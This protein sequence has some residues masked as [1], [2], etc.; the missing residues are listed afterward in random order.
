VLQVD[1]SCGYNQCKSAFCDHPNASSCRAKPF[2]STPVA[3]LILRIYHRDELVHTQKLTESL[4]IGRQNPNRGANEPMPFAVCDLDNPGGTARR[5]LVIAEAN[6]KALSRN[7]ATVELLGDDRVR[8]ANISR[9]VGI[10][11]NGERL[12]P[13]AESSNETS[14]R[15]IE[16]TVRPICAEIEKA[17]FSFRV[18][19]EGSIMSSSGALMTLDL[20]TLAPGA[21]PEES[22]V[23][24]EL[25]RGDEEL[26][27]KDLAKWLLNSMSVFHK[28]AT[29]VEFLQHAAESLGSIVGLDYVAG[30]TYENGEWHLLHERESKFTGTPSTRIL[31]QILHDKRSFRCVPRGSNSQLGI[32]SIVAAPILGTDGQLRGALYGDRRSGNREITELEQM[33]VEIVASATAN[34]IARLE[35][36]KKAM[37][38]QIQF[39][40][41]FG[42]V[43]AEELNKDPTLLNGRETEVSVLF[44]DIRGFSRIS[45]AIGPAQTLRWINDVLN[46]MSVCVVKTGGVLVDYVGDELM[47]MWGA[48]RELSDHADLACK[49]AIEMR[50]K[51]SIL[52]DR[53]ESIIGEKTE[54]GIGINSGTAL[55]GNTGSNLKFKYGPMGTTVNLASRVGSAT[56]AIRR[57]V[58]ITGDTWELLEDKSNA[59]RLCTIEVINIPNAVPVYELVESVTDNWQQLKTDY[60]SALVHFEREE[61]SQAVAV[62]GDVN[63]RHPGDDPTMTL[64]GRAVAAM[65]NGVDEKHPVWVLPTK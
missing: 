14:W 47:A 42:S 60:E 55:V 13:L 56:K 27:A 31:D 61:I 15:D 58:L 1:D 59:R 29:A 52:N 35:Q 44:C 41:F 32:D 54:V 16:V 43:L 6:E 2:V 26:S 49:A 63:R 46:E 28:G 50:G 4:I 20:V 5:K 19:A 23:L 39:E 12:P 7:Q 33:V 65:Q 51:L 34:G 30:L 36:Q 38:A 18:E 8:V 57:N 9:N 24:G 48:P 37:R 25:L 62:L 21:S 53:W 40:E 3:D 10:T 17:E 11:L 22:V 45:D 64:L